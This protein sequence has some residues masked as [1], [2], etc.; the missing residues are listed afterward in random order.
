M[1]T[2]ILTAALILGTFT[3]ANAQ[4]TDPVPPKDTTSMVMLAQNMDDGYVTVK[5]EQLSD[6]IQAAVKNNYPNYTVKA[7]A[8]NAE[9]KLAKITLVAK[10]GGSEKVVIFNEEGQEQK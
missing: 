4:T 8:Y 5:V 6:K 1:K 10:E 7:A 9:Q 2:L 3:F